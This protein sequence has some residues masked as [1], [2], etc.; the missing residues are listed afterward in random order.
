MLGAL[1][2]LSSF[3]ECMSN[4]NFPSPISVGIQG[5]HVAQ[6]LYHHYTKTRGLYQK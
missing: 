5:V 4:W 3:L 2:L 1:C 6:K